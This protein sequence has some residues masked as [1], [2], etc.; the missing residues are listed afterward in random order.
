LWDAAKNIEMIIRSA[1]ELPWQFVIAGDGE[2]SSIPTENVSLLGRVSSKKIVECMRTA[3]IYCLPARYEPFGLSV[4]EAALSSCALVLGDIT[5]LR[6]L[7][8]DAAIF[9]H[10]DDQSG[11]TLAL[12][13]LV[14][15]ERR[16]KQ[17]ARLAAQRARRFTAERM[18]AAYFEMYEQLSRTKRALITLSK[19]C[20]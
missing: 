19:T 2:C 20:A 12:R 4:L 7:W 13:G 15:D 8:N 17:L 14:D 10:P 3:S 16:R 11:L 1:A 9:V 18:A 6:E 5:S